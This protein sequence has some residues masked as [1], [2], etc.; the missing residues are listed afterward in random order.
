M[1]FGNSC[2]HNVPIYEPSTPGPTMSKSWLL[3][4]AAIT[5]CCPRPAVIG[6]SANDASNCLLVACSAAAAECKAGLDAGPNTGLREVTLRA[7]ETGD[8]DACAPVV[9]F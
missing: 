5:R 6:A 8:R 1:L 7:A 9:S 3:A 4:C 2:F